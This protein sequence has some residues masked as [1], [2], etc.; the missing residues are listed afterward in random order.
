MSSRLVKKFVHSYAIPYDKNIISLKKKKGSI[1]FQ[2]RKP[3]WWYIPYD[4]TAF[5]SPFF[6][7]ILPRSKCSGSS[8]PILSMHIYVDKFVQFKMR[9][10]KNKPLRQAP[11]WRC[12]GMPGEAA[13][14]CAT[15][16]TSILR[17]T[18]PSFPLQRLSIRIPGV[19]VFLEGL[20]FLHS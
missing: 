17:I 20:I 5:S 8:Q 1:G 10:S 16:L 2:V 3:G 18:T 19:V 15:K 11:R 6:L 13:D 14:V 9:F 12:Q 7:R 4:L